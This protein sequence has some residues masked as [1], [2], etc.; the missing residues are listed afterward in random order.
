MLLYLKP[1]L[2]PVLLWAGPFA[3]CFVQMMMQVHMHLPQRTRG[4]NAYIDWLRLF[5]DACRACGGAEEHSHFPCVHFAK[6][7]SFTGHRTCQMSWLQ[8]LVGS[9][10]ISAAVIC[11]RDIGIKACAPSTMTYCAVGTQKAILQCC[12]VMQTFQNV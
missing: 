7:V 6:A 9:A 11:L 3:M 12:I 8:N 2:E 10:V 4:Q 1:D 5:L